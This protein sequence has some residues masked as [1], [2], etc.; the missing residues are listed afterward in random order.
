LLKEKREKSAESG[1]RGA[2]IFYEK[3]AKSCCDDEKKSR[4]ARSGQCVVCLRALYVRS[5]LFTFFPSLLLLL[6]V[7]VAAPEYNLHFKER[8]RAKGTLQSR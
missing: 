6:V 8:E 1:R 2:K 3:G 5:A 7:C 4:P